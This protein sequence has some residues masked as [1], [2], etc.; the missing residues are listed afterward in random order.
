MSTIAMKVEYKSTQ[1]LTDAQKG[2]LNAVGLPIH[3]ALK[4]A[5]ASEQ[6]P[7]VMSMLSETA[8]KTY[9]YGLIRDLVV[10]ARQS[11]LT[12]R[13]I[14][15]RQGEHKIDCQINLF[16]PIVEALKDFDSKGTDM[17]SRLHEDY[18]RVLSEMVSYDNFAKRYED[19]NNI[20]LTKLSVMF[21][22]SVARRA[23]GQQ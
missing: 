1:K 21:K 6:S 7:F 11:V 23:V 18:Q 8:A 4:V 22:P 13:S 2:F 9:A 17:L 5:I 10:S 12:A 16:A 20:A 15:S 19:F 3:N 14:L